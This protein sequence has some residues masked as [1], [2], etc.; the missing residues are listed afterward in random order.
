MDD[1][2]PLVIVLSRNYSTGLGV[3]RSLGAA[4]YTVDLIASTK[5]KGS[6]IIAS[7]SKYIRNS[8][9]VL[10][11]KIQGDSGLGL[12][13]ILK[14]YA[15]TS[16]EK[17]VLFPVDD[18]TTSVVDANR[19]FLKE[20]FFI[21]GIIEG[22]QGS[23]VEKMDKKTQ[24]EMARK[25]GILTPLEWTISLKEE[26]MIPQ[27]MVYPCFVKPLQSIS[28]QKTEMKICNN[29][30]E[31][32]QHL[33]RM[34]NFYSERSVLV[35]EFLDVEKEFD[36]SGVCLD[37]HVIIPAV[38]E[39]T[40]IARY[41]LGVTMSGKMISPENL[42]VV[43][44]KIFEMLRQ[45]HY[46]GMFDLELILSNGKIYFNEINFRSGGPNFAYFLSGIN[47]PALYVKGIMGGEVSP[48]EEHVK[49]YGKTFVYEKVAWEDYIH[50]Y[51]SKKELK[52]C[53]EEADYMLLT[54]EDDPK[55]GKIFRKRIFLSAMKNRFK[56]ALK[57]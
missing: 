8:V 14:K 11:P 53:L 47:L 1:L 28:G 41:E 26:V 39:K 6:S 46:N 36:L 27:D 3:I 50:S 23:L 40:K 17:M 19:D 29:N 31:L 52:K 12:M 56:C 18:F 49:A 20:Y 25:A 4:G 22:N 9:E 32:H 13:N 33:I 21:P 57:R 48:E 15:R 7:S 42:G 51:I 10:T 54:N 5:K 24:G 45:L 55:P 35:Q 34:K 30:F 38:I 2:K 44:D 37:Q 16:K 43:K